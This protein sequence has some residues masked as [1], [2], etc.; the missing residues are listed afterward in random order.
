MRATLAL[1]LLAATALLAAG[2]A[3]GAREVAASPPSVSYRIAGNDVSRANTR[4]VDY[5]RQYGL[6][7]QLQGV[8]PSGSGNVATYT[9]TSSATSGATSYDGS[10]AEYGSSAAPYY[11]SSAP[12]GAAAPTQCAD[13]LHQ[14]LPGGSDYHGPPVAGCPSTY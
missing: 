2:C 10:S 13:F 7:A 8:Q 9:C 12:Y 5:C 6:A 11:G 3:N 14:N 1:P 4:A